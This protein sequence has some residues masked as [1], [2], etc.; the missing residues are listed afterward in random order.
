MLKNIPVDEITRIISLA[1]APVFILGA[2]AG[3]L[4]LLVAR[5][6]RVS[7]LVGKIRGR[8]VDDGERLILLGRMRQRAP[9]SSS[10]CAQRP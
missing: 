7:D 1:T 5:L 2:V 4:S 3:L 9:S 6:V 8:A 10:D